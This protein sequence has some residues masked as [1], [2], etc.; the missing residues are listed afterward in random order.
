MNFNVD[1]KFFVCYLSI[2]TN[3]VSRISNYIVVCT[4]IQCN[5]SSAHRPECDNLTNTKTVK[6]AFTF[7]FSLLPV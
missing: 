2:L 1:D 7:F 3:D 5:T 6:R 4:A